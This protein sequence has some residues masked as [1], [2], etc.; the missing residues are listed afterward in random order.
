[1]NFDL[2]RPAPATSRDTNSIASQVF[3]GDHGWFVGVA[4]EDGAPF[5]RE[6]DYFPTRAEAAL[7]LDLPGR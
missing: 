3:R 4:D 1:M 2:A 5:L 6:S 7:A